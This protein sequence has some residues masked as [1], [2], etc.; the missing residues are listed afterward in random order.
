M[1]EVGHIDVRVLAQLGV[2]VSNLGRKLAYVS[3]NQDL[4]FHNGRIN[5]KSGANRE[6]TSFT[7]AIL[8]L[9]DKVMELTVNW[10]SNQWD[11]HTLNLRRL[12]EAE[13]LNDTSDEFGR[14]L[15]FVFW[16]IPRLL[17][18]DKWTQNVPRMPIL[19]FLNFGA[20]F[21]IG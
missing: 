9:S 18:V 8:A 12:Y 7:R 5:A 2:D 4:T 14:D 16:T 15:E 6:S 20:I 21:I 11:R 1:R 13:L 3:D 17:M 19:H 10:L